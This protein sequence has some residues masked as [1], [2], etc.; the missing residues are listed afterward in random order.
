LV[1]RYMRARLRAEAVLR[2]EGTAL[3]A[4]VRDR[5]AELER[6]T[7]ALQAESSERRVAME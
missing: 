6:T 1:V 3:E 7:V 4:S 2:A 5:T